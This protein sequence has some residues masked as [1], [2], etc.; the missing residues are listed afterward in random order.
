MVR[1]GTSPTLLLNT[2][3][4]PKVS[5]CDLSPQRIFTDTGSV[6]I[7]QHAGQDA[8]Q[9][10]SS[11]H[12]MTLLLETLTNAKLMGT[13]DTST[14]GTAWP[15]P[16]ASQNSKDQLSHEKPPLFSLLSSHDFENVAIKTLS[17]KAWAYY[18]SGATDLITVE[19]NKSFYNRVWFRPRILRDVKAVDTTC[20]IQGLK[21]ALPI[22]VSPAAMAKL[23]HPSGE[24]GIAAACAEKGIFQ[25]VSGIRNSAPAGG[26]KV[27]LIRILIE[28]MVLHLV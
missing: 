27:T 22:F 1:Y 24:K 21:S 18:S 10:Y 25:C 16:S 8:T 3:A 20:K 5:S 12:S 23:V 2:L 19:A 4:A 7:H 13:L 26:V 14:I 17:R 9:S 28:R 6:V 15:R 11:V